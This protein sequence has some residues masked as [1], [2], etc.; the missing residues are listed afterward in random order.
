MVSSF[1]QSSLQLLSD[2]LMSDL[3]FD[4]ELVQW[5]MQ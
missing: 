2:F 1:A 5:P 4:L 3:L